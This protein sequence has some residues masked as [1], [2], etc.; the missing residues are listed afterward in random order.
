MGMVTYE[1]YNKMTIEEVVSE[2]QNVCGD[3]ELNVKE[4]KG[5]GFNAWW[6]CPNGPYESCYF[7][8]LAQLTWFM[9]QRAAERA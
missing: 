7:E 3:I 4:A 6:H 2:I 1:K 9:D 8:S 5:G